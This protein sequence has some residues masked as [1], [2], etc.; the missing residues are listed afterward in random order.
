MRITQTTLAIAAASAA[1][2]LT[3]TACGG[4]AP[5][6]QPTAGA[7]GAGGVEIKVGLIPVAEFFPV[8]VA[9]D[10]GF[11]DEAGLNVS[12][13]SMSNAASIVP[14]VLNGQLSIGTAAT[15]PFLTAVEKKIP[16][17]AVANAGNTSSVEGEDTGAFVVGSDS[18]ITS[19]SGLEGKTVAVNALSSLPHVAA[20][21]RIAA[22]GGNPDAVRFVAMPFTDMLT[23]LEQKRVDAILPVEPFMSQSLEA[24]GTSISPLYTGVYPA[25]TTHTLYFA[26]QNFAAE[27]PEALAG[28]REAIAKANEL[29]SKDQAVLRKALVEHGGMPEATAETVNLPAYETDFNLEGM[30]DMAAK[31]KDNGFLTTDVDVEASILK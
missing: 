30:K 29:I 10:Q 21:A 16:V 28:F 19:P 23:A 20:V 24:G 18:G 25:G 27:N 5:A 11:F 17:T 2:S 1:L 14:S 15:P 22:D 12:V 26:S 13:E 6:N 4:A 9:E 31:M 3:L 8:Y 7:G